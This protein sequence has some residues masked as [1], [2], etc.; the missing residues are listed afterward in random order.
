[1]KNKLIGFLVGLLLGSFCVQWIN[2]GVD[3][4]PALRFAIFISIIIGISF[5]SGCLFG[6]GI[7]ATAKI[8]IKRKEN[9]R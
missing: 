4:E 9:E 5:I 7:M 3:I 1:M 8:I 2:D 6:G